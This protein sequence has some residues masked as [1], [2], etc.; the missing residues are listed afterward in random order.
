METT[1]DRRRQDMEMR[2]QEAQLETELQWMEQNP[3]KTPPWV[4]ARMYGS[5]SGT[6]DFSPSI[7]SHLGD[8]HEKPLSLGLDFNQENNKQTRGADGKFAKK[9]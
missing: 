4:E 9:E 7:P 1:F 8:G 2:M 3:G 6:T 5:G